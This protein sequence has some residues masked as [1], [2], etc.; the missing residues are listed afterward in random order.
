MLCILIYYEDPKPYVSL[1]WSGLWKAQPGKSMLAPASFEKNEKFKV[2]G[3]PEI[4]IGSRLV[5]S[6]LYYAW[7]LQG[8]L[9]Q[10]L[11]SFTGMKA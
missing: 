8:T 7:G 3:F 9:F 10:R 11:P 6:E 1:G 2:C 4:K 5:G